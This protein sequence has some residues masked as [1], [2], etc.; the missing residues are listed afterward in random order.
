MPTCRARRRPPI[1]SRTPERCVGGCSRKGTDAPAAAANG[2]KIVYACIGN[3]DDQGSILK[4]PSGAFA[5]IATGLLFVGHTT[6]S[7]DVAREA[8]KT[9]GELDVW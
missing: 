4:A 7:A 8:A 6:G 5:R 2:T 3:N 9:A 1:G